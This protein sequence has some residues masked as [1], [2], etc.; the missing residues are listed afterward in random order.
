MGSRV[1]D[2]RGFSLDVESAERFELAAHL[3]RSGRVLRGVPKAAALA[4]ELVSALLRT[5]GRDA[6]FEPV[7]SIMNQICTSLRADLDEFREAVADG[8]AC[9]RCVEGDDVVGVRDG[10]VRIY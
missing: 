9:G 3:C 7:S 8:G 2:Q 5:E 1:T 10:R 4:E 6:R